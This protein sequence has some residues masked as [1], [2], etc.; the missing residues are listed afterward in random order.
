M[1]RI[2]AEK[3]DIN[4]DN[5]KDFYNSQAESIGNMK[6]PF[7]AV[8]LSN[9]SPE[10]IEEQMKI[11]KEI[12]FPKLKINNESRVLDIGCGIGRW[13]QQIIPQ[14]KSYWGIDFSQKM[15]DAAKERTSNFD[16]ANYKFERMS[17]QDFAAK[18]LDT[19][20]NKVIISAVLMYICD[21][22]IKESI[23]RL[24]KLLDEECVIFI[25]E[26]CGIGQRLTLKDFPS[27]ALNAKYNV[28]YRTKEEY[29]DFFEVFT[30]AGFSVSFS[31][32][33]SKLGG[34]VSYSDTDKIYYIIE[35]EAKG[36][37]L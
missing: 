6:N 20:F 3:V 32:Y 10:L 27:Q 7:S 21:N 24:A 12:L 30:D 17:F 4:P 11:E 33:Y 25:Q 19:K 9:H 26:S 23:K 14:C 1:N 29:D 31:Q 34:K 35:K 15:I 28:I 37:K 18:T 13:A 36:R 16:N 2:Y 5:V 22:D 8:L